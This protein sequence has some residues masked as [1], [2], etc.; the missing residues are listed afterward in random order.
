MTDQDTTGKRMSVSAV[1]KKVA[2]N[3]AAGVITQFFHLVSRIALTPF[4]LSF[5]GLREY[6]L[7]TICFVILSYAGLTAFGVG[8]VY[9]R[10]TASYHGEN[11]TNGISRLLSTGVFAML[12]VSLA[13]Y[14]IL[15]FLAPLL[16]AEHGVDPAFND[17]ARSLILGSAAIFLLDIGL[18]GFRGIL[19]GLQETA[20]VS[21]VSLATVVLEVVLI[22]TLLPFGAGVLGLLYAYAAKTLTLIVSMAFFVF[23]K[24][25]GLRLSPALFDRSMLRVFFVFG[26][27]IQL[28]GFMGIFIDTF[29]KV[30][31]SSMLGLEAVGFLEIGR[32]FPNTARGF[33]SAA[34]GPF[35][36][37]ASYLG[38][39][40][41]DGEWPSFRD[42]AGKYL[43]LVLLGSVFAV[44]ALV[45]LLI[46][47]EDGISIA[48]MFTLKLTHG[49]FII[50][51]V[52][53]ILFI[54]GLYHRFHGKDEYFVGEDVRNLFL[55]GSRFIN[56][57][58]ATVFV[59][60]AAISSRLLFAWVGAGYDEAAIILVL[61]SA[62]GLVHQG[63]GPG[64]LIFRG[65]DRS[66]R[67][68]EYMI[69]QCVLLLVWAPALGELYGLVG[70]SAGFS[71]AAIVASLY[72]FKRT[73]RAFKLPLRHAL[74]R[75]ALP[76][77]APLLSG[78]CVFALAASFPPL[79]RVNTAG[80]VLGLGLFHLAFTMVL[81]KYFFLDTTEWELV[82]QALAK[83]IKRQ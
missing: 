43:R 6:G 39:F 77:L 80:L 7:W 32:K 47:R 12:A 19:E 24:L 73:L 62:A 42:R 65:I 46:M 55:T 41:A 70:V 66:G 57:V 4:I 64:T 71:L 35:M 13:V 74:H 21:W 44:A 26:G 28:L 3:A 52:I 67:E 38:G 29:D 58:N 40:W 20:L 8:N 30:V 59:F 31:A 68:F 2:G 69:I 48:G 82:V 45:P 72:F 56:L 14:G 61:V 15:A 36:P 49:V 50:V 23:R 83:K 75:I 27:K 18:G 33:S 5:I 53:L 54:T 10:Y 16:L 37:A 9:V 22:F 17:M 76:M 81:L 51:A 78:G 25:P 63:T 34:F 1:G 79:S 60:L 11:D